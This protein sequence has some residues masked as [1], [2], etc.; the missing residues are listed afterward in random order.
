ME[1]RQ[2]YLHLPRTSSL[3]KFPRSTLT[4]CRVSL[5]QIVNFT[6]ESEVALTENHYPHSWNVQ[7]FRFYIRN[8]KLHGAWDSLEMLPGH[9]SSVEDVLQKMKELV[10]NENRYTDNVRFSSDN[11]SRKVTIH[12]KTNEE[13]SLN[14]MAYMLGFTPKQIISKT[15]TGDRQVDLEYSFYDLFA[16]C[17]LI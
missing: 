5:P 4:E 17:D 6:G 11:L 8:D 1:V 10:D 7:Q 9:Y 12:L 2:F 13:V 14:D 15:T 3:D 16:Y